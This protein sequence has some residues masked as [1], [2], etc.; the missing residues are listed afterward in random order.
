MSNYLVRNVELLDKSMR[1]VLQAAA[2]VSPLAGA[3]YGLAGGFGVAGILS[4]LWV[5][6]AMALGV[7]GTYHLIAT[8]GRDI[9]NMAKIVKNEG[10]FKGLLKPSKILDF[11]KNP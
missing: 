5:A 8:G 7:L 9:V 3:F 10:L 4:G 6:P 1:N 2:L 11:A